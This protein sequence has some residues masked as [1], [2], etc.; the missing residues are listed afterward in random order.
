[1]AF[2]EIRLHRA[3][4]AE[5]L[6]VMSHREWSSLAQLDD[7]RAVLDRADTTGAKNRL[8]DLIHRTAI[9]RALPAG[10]GVVL[11]FGCGIGRLS[12]WLANRAD[13]V[14][15]LE[16]T[17]EMLGVARRRVT[18]PNVSWVLFDGDRLPL[19]S[20]SI[21]SVV[22]VYVLQHVLEEKR[23]A[24]L[25]LEFARLVVPG[26][27]LVL[28]EQ[29]RQD[30]EKQI[31]GFLEQRLASTYLT[32]FRAA[33][34]QMVEATPIRVPSR[35]TTVLAR[36]NAPESLLVRLSRLS[37]AWT[38]NRL[39]HRSADFLLTFDRTES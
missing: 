27:R 14:I 19:A 29:V 17:P 15:G 20:R 25:A 23:L 31:A 22:S 36:F 37:L 16:V 18:A 1:M 13:L 35:L 10:R 8:V 28:I 3:P 5:G 21:Q 9:A 32:V 39:D 4:V 11:D 38:R 33:G 30:S 6:E 2:V 26:G 7:L 24:D 12:G 34:F